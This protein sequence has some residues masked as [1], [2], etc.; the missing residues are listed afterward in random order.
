VRP[1]EGAA[2]LWRL[3]VLG[4]FSCINTYIQSNLHRPHTSHF[5]TSSNG[6]KPY[7]TT[8]SLITRNRT[9]STTGCSK[10]P[11]HCPTNI[12]CT[13]LQYCSWLQYP[14]LSPDSAILCEV[15]YRPYSS[16]PSTS[17][18]TRTV[19]C[20]GVSCTVPVPGIIPLWT[21]YSI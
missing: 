5:G 1:T 11:I 9:V 8:P 3:V 12:L 10:C 16:T 6:C 17:T 21:L 13:A 7:Y 14:A 2:S 15:N 19:H 20:S 4:T 18:T